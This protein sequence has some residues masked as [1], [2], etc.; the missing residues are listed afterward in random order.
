MPEGIIFRRHLPRGL[1]TAARRL[2]ALELT[3]ES[4]DDAVVARASDLR[5]QGGFPGLY[6]LASIVEQWQGRS[7]PPSLLMATLAQLDEVSHRTGSQNTILAAQRARQLL[8]T[9]DLGTEC[10]PAS[11]ARELAEFAIR[12]YIALGFFVKPLISELV[13]S[14]SWTAQGLQARR[15]ELFGRLLTSRPFQVLVEQIL[16]EPN[17]RTISLPRVARERPKTA[18]LLHVAL[19][20]DLAIAKA[21]E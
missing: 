14:G 1:R 13:E 12:D 7:C 3:Q 18:E 21:R 4:V 15:T 8:Q 10:D 11:V 16:A 2:F 6:E 20:D 9:G 5:R 17:G 19:T